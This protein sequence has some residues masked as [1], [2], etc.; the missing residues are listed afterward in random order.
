MRAEDFPKF[1][2]YGNYRSDSYGSHCLRFSLGGSDYYF[3]YEVLV[4]FRNDK[5]GLVCMKNHWGTT[6]GRHLNCIEP[7]KA[8]RVNAKK[9]SKL[10]ESV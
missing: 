8:K 1:G 5:T 7:D 4:A 3:S 9:F 2:N 6:T 10:L